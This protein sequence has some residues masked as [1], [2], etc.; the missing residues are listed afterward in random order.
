M[1]SSWIIENL[2]TGGYNTSFEAVDQDSLGNIVATGH[3]TVDFDSGGVT[4]EAVVYKFTPSGK[5]LWSRSVGTTSGSD[6]GLGI[7]VDSLDDSIVIGATHPFG[8]G[9]LYRFTADGVLDDQCVINPSDPSDTLQIV[10]IARYINGT[11]Y[12]DSVFV[13]ARYLQSGVP[14]STIALRVNFDFAS[15]PYQ[16]NVSPAG[17]T[18]DIVASACFSEDIPPGGRVSS[19]STFLCNYTIGA[20]TQGLLTQLGSNFQPPSG[21]YTKSIGGGNYNAFMRDACLGY[22]PGVFAANWYAVGQTASNQAGGGAVSALVV[23][24]AGA[25]YWSIAFGSTGNQTTFSAY[26]VEIDGLANVYVL[27]RESANTSV[28]PNIGGKLHIVKLTASEPFPNQYNQP[29]VIWQREIALNVVSGNNSLT[30]TGLTVYKNGDFALTADSSSGP[31]DTILAKFASDGS[32]TGT[33]QGAREGL[34]YTYAASSITFFNNPDAGYSNLA[35]NVQ[36]IT[37][38]SPAFTAAVSYQTTVDLS[39]C[40]SMEP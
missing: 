29:T 21:N 6:A 11:T 16:K 15:I 4:S 36:S 17:S 10:G 24:N 19:N 18:T 14:E 39:D 13:L 38:P 40:I 1:S 8:D 27:I 34:S 33:Y 22:A 30:P 25:G 5:L 2:N 23:K 26:K 20:L 31:Y 32:G 9:Y 12:R 28:T 3:S 37:T 35:A 7:F